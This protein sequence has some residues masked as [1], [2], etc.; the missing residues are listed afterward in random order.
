[1]IKR[2][3]IGV[4]ILFAVLLL[5]LPKTDDASK[6]KMASASML[7]CTQN[8]RAAVADQITHDVDIDQVF[9]NKCPDLISELEVD[10]L[11]VILISS[12]KHQLSITLTPVLEGKQ[13]RWSCRG[14]PAESITSL[15]KD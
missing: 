9:D 5:M 10:E 11:G 7:M 6:K 12:T 14:E 8:F 4:V 1:M 2:M 3:I 15:C 13:I